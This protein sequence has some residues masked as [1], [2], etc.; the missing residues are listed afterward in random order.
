MVTLPCASGSQIFFSSATVMQDAQLFCGLTIVANAS[1]ATGSS[2]NSTLFCLQSSIS[3]E[4]IGRDAPVMSV[5]P[6]QNFLKPP[7]VPDEPTV[8][9]V[10]PA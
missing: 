2:M 4:R 6:R 8:T 9:S 1:M 5:S 7:P 10:L 3:S